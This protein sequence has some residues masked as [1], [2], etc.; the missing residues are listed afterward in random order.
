MLTCPENLSFGIITFLFQLF[1]KLLHKLEI[2]HCYKLNGSKRTL[3]TAWLI[4]NCFIVVVLMQNDSWFQ[5]AVEQSD[6]RFIN[7][8]HDG[9]FD[10]LIVI[11]RLVQWRCRRFMSSWY[12]FNSAAPRTT[13][14]ILKSCFFALS[15]LSPPKGIIISFIIVLLN[16]YNFLA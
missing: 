15:T 4:I 11:G 14:V 13:K 5:W 7:N 9:G 2:I 3:C 16:L 6:S 1:C 10:W 12:D 8:Y